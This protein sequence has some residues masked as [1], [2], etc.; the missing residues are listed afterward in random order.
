MITIIAG[1]RTCNDYNILLS[2][3]SSID[4]IPSTIISG[5]ARGADKLGERWA[6]ENNI[7]LVRFPAQWNK[8]S[9]R[10]GF[11]RNEDMAKKADALIAIW[12][13][14]SSGTKSMIELA[15]KY[16]LVIYITYSIA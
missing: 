5:T 13:G 16:K 4:W 10:A 9:K 6:L 14:Y 1:S 3:I 7:Q 2:A 11:I 12:D 8:Y 15:K